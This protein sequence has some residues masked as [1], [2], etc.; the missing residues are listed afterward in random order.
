VLN[1]LWEAMS[2]PRQAQDEENAAT[3]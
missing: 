1:A 2:L 3:A